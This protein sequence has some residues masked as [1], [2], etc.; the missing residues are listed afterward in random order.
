M[1]KTTKEWC[2]I[3]DKNKCDYPDWLKEAVKNKSGSLD[4]CLEEDRREGNSNGEAVL[5]GDGIYM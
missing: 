2:E 5:L 3:Y 4:S 1:I